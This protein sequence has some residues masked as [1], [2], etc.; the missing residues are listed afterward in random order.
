MKK[1]PRRFGVRR[2][3]R[4]LRFGGGKVLEDF[5]GYCCA[6]AGQMDRLLIVEKTSWLRQHGLYY[7]FAIPFCFM[8]LVMFV[9]WLNSMVSSL[10]DRWRRRRSSLVGT[11]T[12]AQRVVRRVVRGVEDSVELPAGLRK[13][14]VGDGS[15]SRSNEREVKQ[16]EGK[17]GLVSEG[18]R[19]D[20][21]EELRGRQLRMYEQSMVSLNSRSA[22]ES[23]EESTSKRQQHHYPSE[24]ERRDVNIEKFSQRGESARDQV[25]DSFPP[26]KCI[27][28]VLI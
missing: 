11:R 21:G 26:L 9:L 15:E 3:W 6:F 7:L 18:E 23:A 5:S 14:N 4:Q 2:G 24:E 8:G 25:S 1:V 27:S 10:K 28:F 22:L 17:A 20:D 19:H 13:R 12:D 16:R